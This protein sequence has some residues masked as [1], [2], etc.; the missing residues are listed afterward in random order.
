MKTL[1]DY[2]RL[3]GIT[4]SYCNPRC[5]ENAFGFRPCLIG[6]LRADTRKNMIDISFKMI[7]RGEY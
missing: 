3:L 7:M 6:E 4:C 2:L 5:Y 1:W